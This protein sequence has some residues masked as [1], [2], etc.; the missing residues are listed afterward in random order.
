MNV[1]NLCRIVYSY[2]MSEDSPTII[3]TIFSNKVT[4]QVI[5]ERLKIICKSFIRKIYK[6]SVVNQI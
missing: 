3:K 4:T 6:K 5:E 2:K 1:V